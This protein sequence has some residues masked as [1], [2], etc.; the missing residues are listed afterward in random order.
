[1]CCA[2]YHMI[3]CSFFFV[4]GHFWVIVRLEWQGWVQLPLVWRHLYQLE[5]L[6]VVTWSAQLY[7]VSPPKKCPEKCWLIWCY[8]KMGFQQSS[9]AYVSNCHIIY[10]SLVISKRQEWFSSK[11]FSRYV[12][13]CKLTRTGRTIFVT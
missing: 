3:T 1:M 2:V 5:I 7:R 10:L 11:F 6:C 8:L 9:L 4:L 13:K 12:L